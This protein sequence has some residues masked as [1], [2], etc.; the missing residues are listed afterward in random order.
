LQKELTQST[1]LVFNRHC[2]FFRFGH[3]AEP[4]SPSF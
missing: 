2:K 1:R 3:A 4:M